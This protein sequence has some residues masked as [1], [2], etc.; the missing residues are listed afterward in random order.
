MIR[1][2]LRTVLVRLGV[3]LM[4]AQAVVVAALAAYAFREMKEFHYDQSL[5][6]LE[7]LTPLLVEEYT[8]LSLPGLG[9]EEIL[10]RIEHDATAADV[11]ITIVSEDG[12][13]LGDSTADAALMDNHS[14][15]RE[16]RLAREAGEGSAVRFSNTLRAEMMYFAQR[17]ETD[18]TSF[19]VRTGIPLTDVDASFAGVARVLI[20]A[21]VLSL[22]VTLVLIY[23]IVRRHSTSISRLA[24]SASRFAS[25]DLGHRII[26]PTTRELAT[27]AQSLNHM[28]RQLHDRIEELQT[29]RNEQQAILQSMTDG[30]IAL[31][32]DHRI[33]N[34]NHTAELLLG[35]SAQSARGRLL[36]EVVRE[37]EL[38]QFVAASFEGDHDEWAEFNLALDSS[39][40]VRATS[41]PLEDSDGETVGLLVVI[42][43]ITR[44]RR[45][46]QVRR[47][48]AANVSHELRTPITN[49]QGYIETLLEVGVEDREQASQ[50]LAVVKKN[51]DRLKSI[52]EDT[53]ALSRLEE[54][55]AADE[56]DRTPTSVTMMVRSAIG[57]FNGAATAKDITISTE[58][59]DD[60]QVSVCAPMLVL[61]LGNLISNAVAYSPPG[62]TVNVVATSDRDGVRIRVEDQGPGIS[63][64]HQYRVFER[65]Y[66]VDKA[67][68][69]ELGGTGLGLAIV[70][71][72]MRVHGG[73]VSLRSEPEEGSVFTLH[74]P[75]DLGTMPPVIG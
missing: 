36:Q 68:S 4:V 11:R 1:R 70:K 24:R 74:L 48:F 12:T 61:A 62:T 8:D 10:A 53:L 2:K 15:R 19:Y 52:L 29:Q 55:G 9:A 37:P 65:F 6:T 72:I 69:R 30:V 34:I 44:L 60:L 23:I 40:V 66:R 58:V 38:H 28:A 67:R 49:I 14:S 71:H 56:L 47:D 57:Q 20:I 51:S 7:R 16:I 75:P 3:A 31:D 26:R 45:L 13:V 35:V 41:S 25:G 17:V 59:P 54:P 43:E 42:N 33:L 32:R 5:D 22:V 64:D 50:F 27:L 73:D 21:S 46:E 63:R 39:R 18:E